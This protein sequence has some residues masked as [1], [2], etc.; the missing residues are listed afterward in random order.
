MSRLRWSMALVIGMV[1][2]VGIVL[3]VVQS[4]ADEG[5]WTFDNPPRAQWRDRY[6]FDPSS[7]WLDHLR[8]SSVRLN[9]GGSA[10]FV[11]SDGLLITNQHVAGGQLQKV[12]AANRD[13]VRD[14]FYARN[15]AEEIKCPDLEA[16]VLVS[17]ENVTARVE[18]AAR[19]AESDADAAAVR[20]AA[21]AVIEKESQQNTGLRSDVVTL[22][23]GGEYWLYRYKRYTDIRVVFAPE[24][25]MAFFGGDYDNF[26]YPR[27]DLDIAFL[28]VYENGRPAHTADYLR[29]SKSGPSEGEFV[30]LSGHPGS[31]DRM[32]TLTQ[33]KYQR[34]VGNALQ[35]K[36]WETRRDGLGGYAK[37]GPEEARQAGETI[38]LLDNA[39]KRLIGQQRG[40]EK[41]RI[42]GAKEEEERVL[43]GKVAANP[44]WQRAYGDAWMKI[45][46]VYQELPQKAAR[47][48]FSTLTPSRLGGFASTF[49]RYAEEIAKPNEKRL[50]EFRDS[51][52]ES[53]RLSLLSSAPVYPAMEEAI[54]AAWLEGARST[55]GADDPFVRAALE[56]QS[57]ADVARTTIRTTRLTDPAAR[58]ALLDGAPEAIR[59]SADPLMALAR[60]VEPVI[61][62]LRDW[63]DNW[64]RSAE[65]SAG[66]RIAAARFAVYGKTLYPD[67]T[68]TLRL[69]F[70]RAIGYEE[71]TTLVPWKTTLY[72]L[73]D[74]AEGFGEKPPYSLGERWKSRRDRL[75]LATPLDFVYTIDTIGGN[76]GSPL[77]NRNG[78]LV[79]VNFD[80]NQ[81][82]LP[83]RYLYIDEAEGSRAVG[84]HSAA[85]LEALTKIYDAQGLVG[86]LL[87]R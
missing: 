43:R 17:F 74:R 65:T 63:Q 77:V 76:S 83:N 10:A 38:R 56:N 32:L 53:M 49:V 68:F 26:T 21:V 69:G 2:I 36:V 45:D 4:S 41:P 37:R 18:G 1:G 85:I 71:D 22:Y 51:R 15:R 62:E 82:K 55:L 33:I 44:E 23:S 28:R 19:S 29:W 61:R 6:G 54:L 7:A 75:N 47:L 11:S 58:R 48:A 46:T 78:E 79:G 81:Q 39:L 20:R 5:M 30:L 8:L 72:G 40:L 73:Y 27:H 50:D 60:R 57:A 3:T 42:F 16:N 12:S 66:Q 14:G 24:E 80:S 31:T 64:L 70:G 86:E 34:D 84:V 9:D 25:Q 35:R 67:A 52:L 87:R 59:R 13:F